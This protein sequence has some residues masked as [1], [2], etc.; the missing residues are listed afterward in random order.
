MYSEHG[1]V[2]DVSEV[3][4]AIARA[5]VLIVGFRSFPQRLL[6]DARTAAGVGPLVQVVEPLGG[7]EER[8]H[9]LGRHRPQFSVPQRFTFFVWPH[10]VRYLEEAG[11]TNA[12]FA[13][14][15]PGE[16]TEQLVKAL[17]DL[18]RLEWNSYRAAI[19]GDGWRTL[20]DAQGAR[21]AR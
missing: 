9:W 7:V 8:M 15:G 3:N 13:S 1:Q 14:V 21:D 19:N 11:V 2:V 6:V 18:H 12:L 10:S 20:W 16:G 4:E 17:D 5:D